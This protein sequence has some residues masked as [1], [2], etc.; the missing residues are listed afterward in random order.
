[1]TPSLTCSLAPPTPAAAQLD[2]AARA[3]PL[4]PSTPTGTTSR[5]Y[6]W[7]LVESG[8]TCY[9]ITQ[10]F[11][12]T[13]AQ[14]TSWNPAVGADCNLFAGLNY[15]VQGATTASH[16]SNRPPSVT[17][18]TTASSQIS[19]T[20]RSTTR[21]AT[22]TAGQAC[23]KSYRVVSGDYC[24]KIWKD[25]MITEAQLRA[26]NP[27]LNASCDLQIGQVLCVSR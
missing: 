6:R 17:A 9:L 13:Q 16:T 2:P 5:C 22:T 3:K 15:C 11:G 14:F 20:T 7:Y 19:T 26:W 25:N 18:R 24:Y 4:P 10:S 1:M 8:N 12:I 21:P 23:N 27:A